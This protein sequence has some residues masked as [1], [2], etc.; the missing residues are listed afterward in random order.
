MQPGFSLTIA[1][2]AFTAKAGEPFSVKV[3]A[4]RNKYDAPIQLQL[5]GAANGM[6]IEGA[7]IAKGKK[8]TTLKITPPANAKPGTLYAFSI[9][10]KGKK[11]KHRRVHTNQRIAAE[12]IPPNDPIPH[13]TQITTP[14]HHHRV[15]VERCSI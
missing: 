10:G 6:K 1:E 13:R 5:E 12:T 14:H 4:T 8:E 11:G 9:T 3:T 15:T 7:T 2:H